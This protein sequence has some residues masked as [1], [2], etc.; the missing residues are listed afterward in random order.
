MTT[1][2]T[3]ESSSSR[4][5]IFRVHITLT[6]LGTQADDQQIIIVR[7]RLPPVATSTPPCLARDSPSRDRMP[8]RFLCTRSLVAP[9]DR[10]VLARPATIRGG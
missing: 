2:V 1:V 9:D 10:T 3:E 4:G 5:R 6:K 8:A 7:A